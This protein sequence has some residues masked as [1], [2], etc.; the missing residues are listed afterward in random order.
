VY[1]GVML[2]LALTGG[3]RFALDRYVKLGGRS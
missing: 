2:A 1:F 3:G